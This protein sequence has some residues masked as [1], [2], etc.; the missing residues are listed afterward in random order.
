MSKILRLNAG[1]MLKL[2]V[3]YFIGMSNIL[4]KS[5]KFLKQLLYKIRTK[6]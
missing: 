2:T 5:R 1:F 4:R 6:F 3:F